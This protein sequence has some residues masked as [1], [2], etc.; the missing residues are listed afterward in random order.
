MSTLSEAYKAH[1]LHLGDII[2]LDFSSSPSLPDSHAWQPSDDDFSVN[3]P[4]LSSLPVI[5]L[6]DPNAMKLI[7]LACENWGAFHLKNHGIP[8]DVI[9]GAEEEL[10]RL[11]SLPTQQKLKALRSPTGTTGYGLPRIS[12]F[13]AKCMWH[14]GFTI[15]DSPSEDAKKIWP[16][17]YTGFW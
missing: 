9:Q 1:T 2:P 3:D 14:E 15:I 13:F 10:Q 17:D 8:L 4:A 16:D 7:G 5:D 11:F 6:M 12:P